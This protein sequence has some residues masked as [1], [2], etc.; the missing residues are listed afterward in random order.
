MNEHFYNGFIKRANQYGLSVVEANN[1]YKV[2]LDFNIPKQQPI[3]NLTPQMAGKSI[4]SSVLRNLPGGIAKTTPQTSA[5]PVRNKVNQKQQPV[6]LFKPEM[7]A[8]SINSQLP[9]NLTL[10]TIP[11]TTEKAVVPDVEFPVVSPGMLNATTN[12]SFFDEYAASL[13]ARDRAYAES[14]RN[15]AEQANWL[16]QHE[17]NNARLAKAKQPSYSVPSADSIGENGTLA[18]YINPVQSPFRVVR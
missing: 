15:E 18:S 1:L 12:R 5:A 6:E 14:L 3:Q 2:A 11:A 10:N 4:N 13:P 16:K 9:L 8:K 17:E 7:V